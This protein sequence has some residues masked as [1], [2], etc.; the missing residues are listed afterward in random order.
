MVSVIIDSEDV[1]Y[2]IEFSLKSC[3]NFSIYRDWHGNIC[4]YFT[5]DIT[6]RFYKVNNDAR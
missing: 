5:F 4:I 1:A 2:K 6:P 3:S